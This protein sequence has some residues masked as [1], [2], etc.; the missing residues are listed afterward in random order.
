MAPKTTVLALTASPL[1]GQQRLPR[2][3]NFHYGYRDS[4]PLA[5]CMLLK[6]IVCDKMCVIPT[7][8]GISALQDY[9]GK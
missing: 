6:L 2:H 4:G 9:K 7:Q 3:V 8:L 5:C 1:A